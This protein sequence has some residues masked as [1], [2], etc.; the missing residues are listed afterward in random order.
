MAQFYIV[1]AFA[2]EP[3]G[4]NPAGVVWLGD[5]E[6]P[7]EDSMRRLAA[8][9][10]YSETAFVRRA[11]PLSGIFETRYFTPVSEVDLCGHATIGAFAALL[12]AGAVGD[13]GSCTN[14]TKAGDL[15]ISVTDGCVWMELGAPK[16]L[17]AVPDNDELY[18][19]MGAARSEGAV[20]PMVSAGLPDILLPVTDE[21]ALAAL[22]PDFG[23][24]AE[25]SERLDVVGV[26]AFTTDA[27]DGRVHTRN[28][29]PL[30][31]IDEEAATGTSSG[32]LAYHLYREGLLPD[33]GEITF[34]QG[35]AMGRPSEIVA[36]AG[37]RVYV[38][39]RAV[40]LAKGEL[41]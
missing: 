34:I 38:G 15:A 21:A 36:R 26:H 37:D 7:N 27:Q 8:E 29:A 16:L 24:L 33:G 40:L 23:A 5:A 3:F 4:G 32:A 25:L 17:G 22:N 11:A 1:D 6:F 28:F 13:G 10:R 12:E 35:E 14:R 41:L 2:T 9:F 39:G 20:A 31:G 19:I 18:S 30:V